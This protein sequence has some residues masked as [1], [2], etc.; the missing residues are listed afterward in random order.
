MAISNLSYLGIYTNAIDSAIDKAEAALKERGLDVAAID[1]MNEQAVGRIEEMF[2]DFS[3]VTNVIIGC[4][5][6]AALTELEER[7]PNLETDYYV[8]GHDSHI[9]VA[10]EE[11][12]A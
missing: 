7:F 12:F 1:S 2:P 8:N 6:E 9:Y 5:F 11:V 10:G 3:E 4:Y